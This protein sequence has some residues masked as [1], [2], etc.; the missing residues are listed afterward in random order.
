ME[1]DALENK[2]V[3]L[4]RS[5]LERGTITTL[6]AK[7]DPNDKE[8]VTVDGKFEDERGR[9]SNFQVKFRV[10]QEEVEVL[11]WYVSG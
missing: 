4:L 1:L 11:S 8:L 6:T 7:V 2:A 10:R 9:L 5:R 3:E